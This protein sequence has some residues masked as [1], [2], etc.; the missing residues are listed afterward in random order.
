MGHKD[1][2]IVFKTYLLRKLF[3]NKSITFA[4]LFRLP[5]VRRKTNN[6]SGRMPGNTGEQK[7]TLHKLSIWK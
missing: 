4:Q 5:P 1:T 3:I 6:S 7:N 2:D